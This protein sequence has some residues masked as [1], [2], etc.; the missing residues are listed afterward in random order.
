MVEG[1]EFDERDRIDLEQFG[2]EGLTPLEVDEL[3]A[4]IRQPGPGAL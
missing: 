4:A 2:W 3:M 1:V